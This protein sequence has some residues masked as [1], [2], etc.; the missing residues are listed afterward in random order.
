MRD[1]FDFIIFHFKQ[2]IFA[3]SDLQL[4]GDR[5]SLIVSPYPAARK[6]ILRDSGGGALVVEVKIGGDFCLGKM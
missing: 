3:Y 1:N 2:P 5:C 4:F 6:K